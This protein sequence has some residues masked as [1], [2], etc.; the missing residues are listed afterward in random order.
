MTTFTFT[1]K[2]ST[3]DTT[4]DVVLAWGTATNLIWAYGP[5]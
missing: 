5:S 2:L 1:K 3:G 4:D